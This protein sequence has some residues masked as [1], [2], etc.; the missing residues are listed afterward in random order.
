MTDDFNSTASFSCQK[1]KCSA[2]GILLPF[3]LEACMS[4][5]L[6][7]VLYFI[8][9]LYLFLGIAIVADIFMSSIETITSRRRKIRYPDPTENDKYL[10]VE[11][12][13]WNDTVAN[14]TLMA[15]GSSSPEILLSIIE[16][17]GNR[18][19][20]GELGPGT[21]VGSAAYNLLMICAICISAIKAPET[22]RIKL[23]SVFMVTSFFGFFAYIWMFIVLSII[24]KDV[25]DLWEAVITFLLFPLVVII[26]FLAEKNFYVSKKIDM[27]EEEQTLILT[28]PEHDENGSPRSFRKNEL[29]QFLRDLGQTTNLSLEDKAQ[30]FAAKLSE[31]MHRSRMQY[32]IQ[33][34]RMLTGGKSLFLNLPDK[35]QE[36][37][38]E[39]SHREMLT[40]RKASWTLKSI[41]EDHHSDLNEQYP[42]IEFSTTTYA[43]LE[44]EQRVV[45][46]IKRWGAIDADIRFRLDTIDGT[47]TAGEDYVKLSEEFKMERGQQEKRITIHVI[48]DNQWEPDET[49]FVKLSLPEGEETHAKLGSKTIALVTI[50]NDDEPGF[51]EFEESITLVKESI[52]KAEI[53]LVRS[54][55]ADG[56][57]S[58]HYRTKDIDAVATK[59][60]EPAQSE[61]IFEHGEISK[62]IAIPIM[63]D[64]EAEKDESFAV[65]LYDP[66]GGAQLGKHIKTVVT[67]INDDDYKTMANRMA[68]LVQV[69]MDKLSVTKTS[70]GQQFRDAMN[71]NG[72]DLETA[73]FGHY[74]GHALAFFWKVLFALVPPTAIAGGWLTFFVSL[75][76]IAILTAIVGDVAAIFGC[77]VGLKDSI[78][79]ISFVALGTSLPDTFASM[80]A[81]KNS[82]TADDAIGN[83]TGSNSVNV[84]LGLGLPWLIAASYWE[85]KNLPFTVKAGDLSFSVLVF[86]V[87]CILSMS[88]LI[89]RRYASVFGNAELGGPVIPKYV[90][91]I[92]FICLW[93]G[94]LT[95][96]G[97]QAYGHIKWHS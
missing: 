81:A 59:D 61:I 46:K 41:D 74:I 1:F 20:A 53:K 63:N 58:V 84:F 21:I 34:S 48:D 45:L 16:I 38:S 68:S 75:I 93:I 6:R 69:D 79:A 10:T 37:Y 39:V 83:V 13:I 88:V 55:G 62:I 51:I 44:C 12:R 17:I 28:P 18:F 5:Q 54:N 50:I 85:S 26:A 60:Y 73:K 22:R 82:K 77:L 95:L 71:V 94:Y 87:C 47:A 4:I 24:S 97:L 33:G 66:T 23:Y 52:G 57:V 91:S 49:F 7:A 19:E 72:G 65:E 96:S 25:V 32:R 42:T 3:G 9:L 86:S 70:W 2:R 56:R 11:V 64:L 40:D 43:V 80:I 31:S 89:I 78:T 8:F 76:F 30:L 27:E 67:I 36:I 92:F 90:C 29:L 14:L 15:L 35:L